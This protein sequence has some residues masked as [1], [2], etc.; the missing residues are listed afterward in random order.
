MKERK[1]L[2]EFHS[3]HKNAINIIAILV[4]LVLVIALFICGYLVSWNFMEKPLNNSQFELCEQVARD[5]Y[6][7]KENVIVESPEEVSV[8]M[9]STTI[10]VQLTNS[11]YRGKVNA[12][13]QNGELVMTRDMETG[14]AV[15]VSILMGLLFVLIIILIA[16]VALVIYEG[17]E[18]IK[19]SR[20]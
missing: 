14:E 13:L 7:Q 2:K 16:L 15:F 8:S 5:V 17:I 11:L 6:A 20:K 1:T 12:R 18:G 4:I 10:T 19:E 9:T 3:Q